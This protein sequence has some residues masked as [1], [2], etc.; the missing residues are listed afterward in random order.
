MVKT[1]FPH[2]DTGSMRVEGLRLNGSPLYDQEA[3]LY[4]LERK[5]EIVGTGF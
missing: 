3:R 4:A 2:S 5:N 1:V